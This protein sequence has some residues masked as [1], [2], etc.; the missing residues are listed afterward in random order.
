MNWKESIG[1]IIGGSLRGSLRVRLTANSDDVQEGSF[2][3]IE[4]DKMIFYG[5]VT[6]IQL[7][8]TDP[9]FADE[10]FESRVDSVLAGM[11]QG[12]TLFTNL[13]VMPVLMQDTVAE[14]EISSG[15]ENTTPRP[16]KTVPV[17]HSPVRLAEA[18]DIDQIFGSGDKKKNFIVG[19]TR[20]QGLPIRIDMEKFVKRSSGIF[21]ATGTGKS[22]LT[23]M[24]LA[25][26]VQ[27]DQ[28]SMLVFDM[29]NEYAYTGLDSD[30]G[31]QVHGLHDKFGAKVS[32]FGLGADTVIHGYHPETLEIS[33][34]DIQP[35]DILL[36]SKQLNLKETSENT[37]AAL[38]TTFGREKW[39][40]KF[41]NMKSS[42]KES[43]N[44]EKSD[45]P[46]D[47]I[48]GW[49]EKVG[50]NQMAAT[51]FH[52]KLRR[53]FNSS[54][55]IEA[56]RIASN[57]LTM[58]IDNL[59]NGRHVILSFGKHEKDLDYLLVA[60][61]L[62]RR[63]RDEWVKQSEAYSSDRI[64]NPEPRPLVFVIEE[65]HKLMSREM[66]SQTIFSTIARE[67][68]KY[69][70]TLLVVDQRPSQIYDEVMSQLG[71]RISG[72]LGDDADI[73]AVLSGLASKEQL[74]GMLSHLQEKEEV[75]LLGWGVPMPMPVRSRRYD[76]TFWEE[77]LGKKVNT[78]QEKSL[79]E[80]LED[81]GF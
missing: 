1:Y 72:W 43:G 12:Q 22:F 39:F 52:S 8:A 11:L 20:E 3:V 66:A 36:L 34:A 55:L 71:T 32:V 47:S 79:E 59:K 50:V 56:D 6:D 31:T 70:V 37:L 65:A 64:S 2:A 48:Q 24:I 33:E 58:M 16:V 41:K 76:D 28:S 49:A 53:L 14:D 57:G 80:N 81:L 23:R 77:I 62:T 21:G 15:E 46:P 44:S 74:R 18:G 29:H 68:R 51:S 13:E 78:M 42:P 25:G 69:Y 10:K 45:Y 19:T 38:V 9:R 54:Y 35:E 7:G 30:K 63:I 73:S 17:H 27:Y 26:L 60:N 4:G 40:T 67:M 5:L 61:L 75:L